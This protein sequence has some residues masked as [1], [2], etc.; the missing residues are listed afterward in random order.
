MPFSDKECCIEEHSTSVL[1]TIFYPYT[2]LFSLDSTCDTFLELNTCYMLVR[3]FFVW[4]GSR[5][6]QKNNKKMVMKYNMIEMQSNYFLKKI[7]N[8]IQQVR[9]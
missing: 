6:E 1:S 5:N 3:E 4:P 8:E 2:G 7:I 9:R